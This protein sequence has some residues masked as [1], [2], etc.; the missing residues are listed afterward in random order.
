MQ[1]KKSIAIAYISLFLF[2]CV[3]IALRVYMGS[4]ESLLLF[5]GAFAVMVFFYTA[6]ALYKLF[7]FV[8]DGCKYI[9]KQIKTISK[10]KLVLPKPSANKQTGKVKLVQH[11]CVIATPLVLALI[12]YKVNIIT[13]TLGEVMILAQITM[14]LYVAYLFVEYA[15]KALLKAAYILY[16]NK[17]L[18]K[19]IG[20]LLSKII[21]STTYNII[22]AIGPAIYVLAL[23]YIMFSQP[24]TAAKQVGL[25]ILAKLG[26]YMVYLVCN[27]IYEK[28]ILIVNT[29]IQLLKTSFYE[30]RLQINKLFNEKTPSYDLNNLVILDNNQIKKYGEYSSILTGSSMLI[31]N[32]TEQIEN[33]SYIE[34]SFKLAS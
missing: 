12:A 24:E 18:I 34:Q 8:I 22:K 33:N 21:I 27:R 1:Q 10:I 5:V 13:F 32:S 6:E 31:S 2:S 3:A 26:L 14:M 4:F 7:C 19:E 9:A 11:V 23:V 29:V 28:K 25:A 30:Q 16:L 20:I 17:G 15:F